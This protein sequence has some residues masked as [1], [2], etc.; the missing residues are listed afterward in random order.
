MYKVWGWQ[1]WGR[2]GETRKQSL[3]RVLHLVPSLTVGCWAETLLLNFL[4]NWNAHSCVTE[5][6]RGLNKATK[7]EASSQPKTPHKHKGC[8]WA[9]GTVSQTRWH[10]A[11]HCGPGPP[12][13]RLR[14]E[15]G[16]LAEAGRKQW[17]GEG[18]NTIHSP[19]EWPDHGDAWEGSGSFNLDILST[20][21]LGYQGNV[22][23]QKMCSVNQLQFHFP[24]PVSSL[25]AGPTFFIIFLAWGLT[26][27]SWSLF[28]YFDLMFCCVCVCVCLCCF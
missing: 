10:A 14:V 22:M 18:W 17:Q 25:E 4:Q 21:T 1:P 24:P 19:P 28:L 27:T 2:T 20:L 23:G 7:G 6:L 11:F 13:W 12:G 3:K 5:V 26:H 9:E 8:D 15:Q 16:S